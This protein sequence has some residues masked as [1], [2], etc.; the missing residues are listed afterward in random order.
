MRPRTAR[1]LIAASILA[2]AG[3]IAALA[4]WPRGEPR[5]DLA[6]V[7]PVTTTTTSSTTTTSA[8][9]TTAPPSTTTTTLPPLQPGRVRIPAIG[10]DARVVPVG[11]EP[12]G[13]M[14]VPPADQVGWYE[15]GTRP[16]SPQG[17]AVLAAHVDYGGRRGA[18]FSL[19]DLPEGAE[20]EV[21][22]P[23]GRV[24]RYVVD[25]RLQVDK[26]QLPVQ[27]LFRSTGPPTLTLITC[28]GAFDRSI[29]HYRDNIVIRAR[30]A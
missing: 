5:A 27:E 18:F 17:S 4:W 7:A 2:L 11:L 21:S 30:P 26:R 3:V 28:G 22:D 10:V 14:E 9:T 24:L 19:R 29:R 6:S 20:I 23:D 8:P 25:T 12:N 1:I 15:L 13:E 16:G